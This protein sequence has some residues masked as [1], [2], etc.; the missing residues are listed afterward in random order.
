MIERFSVTSKGLNIVAIVTLPEEGQ[1]PVPCVMLSH[2]LVSSKESSK[3]IML[4]NVLANHGIAS[5]RLDF[6]GCGESEG[7]IRETTLTTR[8]DNLQK[9]V[10]WARSRAEINP[11][12]IG[13]LGS[14]F[15]SAT[16]LA[17]AARD[18]RIACASFW[19]TPYVLDNKEDASVDGIEFQT[20]LFEDF[21]QYDLLKEA[22][23]VSR[24][25]VIHGDR[26]EV[27]PW[28]EGKAIYENLREPKQFVLIEGGDHTFS[29]P[30]HRE[31]AFSPAVE[32]FARFLLSP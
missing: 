4:A 23:T 13:L 17:V 21:A 32:W 24:G 18:S 14:S 20:A 8:I 22:R 6:H 29:A 9:V 1:W 30:A 16:S 12:R 27:V 2:G 15:G 5:C 7:D 10:A 11:E 26:D 19:A 31:E 3:Y 25:L 28:T